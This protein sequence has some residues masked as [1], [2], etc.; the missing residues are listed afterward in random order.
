MRYLLKAYDKLRT[1]I[2][3]F[4][5][6]TVKKIYVQVLHPDREPWDISMQ[7]LSEFADGT[8]GQRFYDFFQSNN[9]KIEPRYEKHDMFHVI[10]GY[11]VGVGNELRIVFFMLGNGKY[12]VFNLGAAPVALLLYPDKWVE[13]IKHYKRGKQFA[14]LDDYDYESMLSNNFE[15][16]LHEIVIGEPLDVA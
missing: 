8:L 3:L 1:N 5:V 9:I 2:L 15:E 10:S 12:S 7:S 16:L 4:G 14:Y 13:F 11:G 6:D